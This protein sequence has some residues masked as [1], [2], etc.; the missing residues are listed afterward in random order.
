ML[1]RFA[2]A[3]FGVIMGTVVALCLIVALVCVF[4]LPRDA[5]NTNMALDTDN[6]ASADIGVVD[7]GN[8]GYTVPSD[9]AT[10]EPY[11]L[12][13]MGQG[14]VYWEQKTDNGTYYELTAEAASG[15]AFGYWQT[16]AGVKISGDETIRVRSYTTGN[17]VSAREYVPVF[18]ASANVHYVSN[19]NEIVTSIASVGNNGSGHIYILRNDIDTVSD[20]ASPITTFSGVLDGNGHT[21]NAISVSGSE[22]SLGGIVGT[23]SGGVIKDLTIRSGSVSGTATSAQS[24][25]A[26]AGTITSGLISRCVNHAAVSG[27]AT[28]VV[29]GIVAVATG[30]AQ[31]S[32]LY[33]NEN[34]GSVIGGSVGAIVF[35]NTVSG[36]SNP[37]AYLVKN[38]YDGSFQ[39]TTVTA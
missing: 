1:G 6:S 2:T 38:V 29:A 35:T 4:C 17:A 12:E 30:S 5:G 16:S 14:T 31:T 13:D 23:L 37:I 18:I 7:N 28:G 36:T 20:S 22:A 3:R 21:I 26:F 32:A 27:T 33:Y 8:G 19:L 9:N 15:Y 24:V 11:V 25:G 34:H 39:L 10:P